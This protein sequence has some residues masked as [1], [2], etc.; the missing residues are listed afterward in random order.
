MKWKNILGKETE[1]TKE[2]VQKENT[3]SFL[4]SRILL[5]MAL[6]VFVARFLVQDALNQ[7]I[8]SFLSI[9]LLVLSVSFELTSARM[10]TLEVGLMVEELLK[11]KEEDSK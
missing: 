3:E 6:L 10:R 2:A 1:V 7:Q 9:M 11:K 4:F 8:A 5:L